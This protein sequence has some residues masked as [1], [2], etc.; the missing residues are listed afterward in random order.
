M[1]LLWWSLAPIVPYISKSA[2]NFKMNVLDEADE[3]K[4]HLVTNI[5]LLTHKFYNVKLQ[6]D[7]KRPPVQD[8]INTR[9]H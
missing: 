4:F 7:G 6:F 9:Q 5:V 1:V 3:E 2:N 8:E